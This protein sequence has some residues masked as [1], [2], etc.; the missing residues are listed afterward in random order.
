MWYEKAAEQ[1][2]AEAQF[3][4][5]WMYSEGEGAPEDLEKARMWYEKVMEQNYVRTSEH[6]HTRR[7]GCI[8]GVSDYPGFLKWS[9]KIAAQGLA[10]AQFNCGW[11]YNQGEGTAADNTKARIRMYADR[12]GAG[13][14]RR[15]ATPNC[16][17][18]RLTASRPKP[19]N[20][21]LLNP[22]ITCLSSLNMLD[23]VQSII[24][25]PVWP[26]GLHTC[27]ILSFSCC[28]GNSCFY[29][30][31]SNS[32]RAGVSACNTNPRPSCTQREEL[33]G[34]KQGVQKRRTW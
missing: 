5:G 30:I 26:L 22:K 21:K 12:S 6:G 8:Y 32:I 16:L 10:T 24:S 20:P 4:C 34:R 29:F 27:Q 14:G 19:L 15:S 1:G 11:M 9:E 25:N 18:P 7:Y 17:Y 31:H 23:F 13:L 28:Q 33:Y 3:E 2:L